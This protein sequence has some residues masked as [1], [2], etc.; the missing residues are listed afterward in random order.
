MHRTT[1]LSLALL[2][3]LTGPLACREPESSAAQGDADQ[4]AGAALIDPGAAALPA[5]PPEASTL[6]I[7]IAPRGAGDEVPDGI[8]IASSAS[9]AASADAPVSSART[10]LVLEPPIDG[11]LVR[12]DPRLITF[13]PLEPLRPGTTYIARLES[14]EV[15]EWVVEPQE[16]W[17]SE[18]TTPAFAL[19]EMMTPVR[20]GPR[21]L[22]VALRFSAPPA[23][24]DL[25]PFASWRFGK[26]KVE[27]TYK[28]EENSN[29]VIATLEGPSL[30]PDAGNTLSLSLASGVPFD[31]TIAA[32][33]ASFETEVASGPPVAILAAYPQEDAS[34][35]SI[36]VVCDDASAPGTTR[37]YW[38][39]GSDES[40]RLRDACMPALATARQ[41]ITVEPAV[42][43]RLTS[44]GRG[45]FKLFGEFKR[46]P[47]TLRIEPG[48]TTESGGVTRA[49]FEKT[50]RI[51]AR[52]VSARFASKGRYLPPEAWGALPLRM[53]NVE[54][55]GVEVRH[56]PQAN[57]FFWEG[58]YDEE[59]G[60]LVADV[61]AT[62]ELA[63][64]SEPRSRGDDLAR[65]ARARARAEE[66][67]LRSAR[68]PEGGQGG[69]GARG[70]DRSRARRQARR[71]AAG[72]AVGAHDLGLGRGA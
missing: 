24:A 21:A 23:S 54:T 55:L 46:G 10:R 1:T 59:A 15:G 37:Y 50:I 38:D 29:R 44:V 18:F 67:R 14:V 26:K 63:I 8:Q 16:P 13:E 66:G 4:D 30:G 68:E 9:L 70:R 58:Q 47:Y 31:D 41:T 48:M 17:A 5:A 35:Y 52:S 60:P 61:V 6:G 64:E 33:E 57:A 36:R 32:P 11:T 28:K 20:V 19:L 2:L 51:P 34:G 22:R 7:E 53:T 3:F 12:N 40:Y 65:S 27:A 62:D 39:R 25:S 49:L 42:E 72:R 71:R 56:V 45:G 69:R 43:M